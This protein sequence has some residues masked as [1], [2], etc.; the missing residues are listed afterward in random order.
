MKRRANIYHQL[1]NFCHRF[2]TYIGHFVQKWH[3]YY[4]EDDLSAEWQFRDTRAD[5]YSNILSNKRLTSFAPQ[6][7]LMAAKS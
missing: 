5:R 2:V 7:D 4:P 1:I 6:S 3:Q